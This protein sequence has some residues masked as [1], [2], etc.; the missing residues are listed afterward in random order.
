M[1]GSI[2]RKVDR[3]T[4]QYCDR[5][6]KIGLSWPRVC[7]EAGI[8]STGRAH[9]AQAQHSLVQPAVR[10]ALGG[11]GS[12]N[13]RCQK[14]RLPYAPRVRLKEMRFG[15]SF[16]LAAMTAVAL[17]VDQHIS[18]AVKKLGFKQRILWEGNETETPT[19]SPTTSSVP[20]PSPSLA[21]PTTRPSTQGIPMFC[22]NTDGNATNGYDNNC[23][24][25]PAAYMATICAG[26]TDDSD[27]TAQELCWDAIF[28]RIAKWL[29]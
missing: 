25:T 21:S 5:K 4:K 1:M 14:D 8:R 26:N 10:T 27:F 24:T 12:S 19:M 2:N 7:F 28:F 16:C 29:L 17:S 18:A 23:A 9:T 3:R 13:I 6:T 15:K 11:V 22:Q 20:T